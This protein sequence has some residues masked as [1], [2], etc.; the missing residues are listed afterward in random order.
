MQTQFQLSS[1]IYAFANTTDSLSYLL[2]LIP[3]LTA[4]I[5]IRIHIYKRHKPAKV[6]IKSCR[7]AREC[8]S[9]MHAWM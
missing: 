5:N 2:D 8:V 7:F 1:Y 9:F 4:I 6:G 3:T